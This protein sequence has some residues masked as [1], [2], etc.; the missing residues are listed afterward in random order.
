MSNS[1]YVPF[2]ILSAHCDHCECRQIAKKTAKV[3]INDVPY[4]LL[5]HIKVVSGKDVTLVEDEKKIILHGGSSSVIFPCT[6]F[7]GKHV[8]CV[9][10][11]KNGTVRVNR[12]NS[13]AIL[14]SPDRQ[15]KR[16]SVVAQM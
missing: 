5:A 16:V 6:N 9:T 7:G 15:K 12:H 11:D 1:V 4:E 10:R 13:D 2:K 8:L 14:S 3:V